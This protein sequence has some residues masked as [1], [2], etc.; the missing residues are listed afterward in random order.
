M[1]LSLLISPTAFAC[2]L[3]RP[4]LVLN[5]WGQCI[6]FNLGNDYVYYVLYTLHGRAKRVYLLSIVRT[7]PLPKEEFMFSLLQNQDQLKCI[8]A[9]PPN[10]QPLKVAFSKLRAAYESSRLQPFAALAFTRFWLRFSRSSFSVQFIGRRELQS[11]S[12]AKAA[13]R[14]VCHMVHCMVPGHGR[15]SLAQELQRDQQH[16]LKC[17]CMSAIPPAPSPASSTLY[18]V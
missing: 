5:H 13:H 9:T 15:R 3:V 7:C 14:L 18:V 11:L 17:T 2:L 12:V 16:L 6:R 10:R 8:A 4:C 1:Q